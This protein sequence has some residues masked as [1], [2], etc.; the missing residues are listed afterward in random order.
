MINYI[1]LKYSINK[2]NIIIFLYNYLIKNF[3]ANNKCNDNISFLF[4]DSYIYLK[5]Q[6]SR[7]TLGIYLL[8]DIRL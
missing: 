3:L 5:Y 8:K 4:N 7:R 2:F 6:N 1:L